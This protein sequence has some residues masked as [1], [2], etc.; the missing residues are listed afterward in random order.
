V[1]LILVGLAL[2]V[3]GL[4]DAAIANS[5]A[6]LNLPPSPFDQQRAFRDLKDVR[7]TRTGATEDQML[8]IS[9]A[10]S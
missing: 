8:M 5:T 7:G 10:F 3:A 4:A 1:I 6:S 9:L 2:L